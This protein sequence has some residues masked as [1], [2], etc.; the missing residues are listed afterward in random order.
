[1][2]VAEGWGVAEEEV[3]VDGEEEEGEVSVKVLCA[4]KEM[5]NMGDSCGEEIDDRRERHHWNEFI[6]WRSFDIEFIY[7]EEF[8]DSWC[9]MLTIEV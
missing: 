7:V 6:C 5:E 4:G 1:M 9:K 2:A 8:A 3:G